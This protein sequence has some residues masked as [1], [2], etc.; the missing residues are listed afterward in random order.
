M[1]NKAIYILINFIISSA[2]LLFFLNLLIKKRDYING[3]FI[4]V[5]FFIILYFLIGY[6]VPFEK[7]MK[8]AKYIRQINLTFAFVFFLPAK[9]IINSIKNFILIVFKIL[10]R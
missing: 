2:I 3:Y 4:I 5:I 6:F 1:N 10:K 8:E 9:Y 7:V